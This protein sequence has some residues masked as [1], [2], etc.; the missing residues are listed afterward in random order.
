LN[1]EGKDGF[2][3]PEKSKGKN[4]KQKKIEMGNIWE[5]SNQVNKREQKGID[6]YSNSQGDKN[7]TRDTTN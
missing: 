4:K 1:D 3:K 2:S 5:E 6:K 7:K